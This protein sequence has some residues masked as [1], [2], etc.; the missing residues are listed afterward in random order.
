MFGAANI[1]T[2]RLLLL[3]WA[4]VLL[5]RSPPF[6]FLA[7]TVV[8]L[9]VIMLK[10]RYI[11]HIAPA[12]AYFTRRDLFSGQLATGP[13]SLKF[14][15][16]TETSFHSLE[17][18]W[19]FSE[20]LKLHTPLTETSTA[21]QDLLVPASLKL[22]WSFNDSLKLHR[23]NLNVKA[24]SNTLQTLRASY[25]DILGIIGWSFGCGLTG[26]GRFLVFHKFLQTEW[27]DGLPFQ[28]ARSLAYL[29]IVIWNPRHKSN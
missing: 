21:N 10:L 27:F 12:V 16:L 9:P 14:Q 24:L 1:L 11:D 28:A 17:L 13:I 2:F 19:G 23:T 20:S 5:W 3:L 15:W 25:N 8:P 29:E 26:F 22:H 4:C 7:L 18:D 6:L